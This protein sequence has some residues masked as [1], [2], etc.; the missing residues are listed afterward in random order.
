[1]LSL[2][3]IAALSGPRVAVAASAQDPVTAIAAQYTQAGHPAPV[4]TAGSTGKFYQQISAG[5]PFDLLF[6]ADNTYTAR[7]QGTRRAYARGRLALWAPKGGL[8]VTKGWAA[9]RAPGLR[10]VAIA[11]PALA[12]YG[13]AAEAALRKAGLYEL[14]GPKLVLGESA[15]QATQFVQA[16]GA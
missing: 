8:D 2:L 9:L 15:A 16:G 11:N 12:P 4:L 10:H 14:I 7:L 5:A 13:V 1:M 6:A 3:L